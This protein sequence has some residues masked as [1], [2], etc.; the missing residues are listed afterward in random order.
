MLRM[1]I[2]S[3]VVGVGLSAVGC[4]PSLGKSLHVSIPLP[5]SPERLVDRR[6]QLMPV[7]VSKV[8]DSRPVP[9]LAEIDGRVVP[10][11]F[12]VGFEVE[13]ALRAGLKDSDMTLSEFSKSRVQVEITEWFANVVVDF[14][15]SVA[16]A[17]AELSLQVY[18]GDNQL[19]YRGLFSGAAFQEH[20]YLDKAKVEDTLGRAMSEAVNELVVDLGSYV[21]SRTKDDSLN[22]YS[23]DT[24]Q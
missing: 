13:K 6:A 24:A 10:P 16:D 11:A 12:N 1:F 15:S 17:R 21:A 7:T 22:S 5:A 4:A 2:L 18:D 14:P 8:R 23:S 20:P 9:E 3:C 19:R